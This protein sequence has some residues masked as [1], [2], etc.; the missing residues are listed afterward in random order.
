MKV[1]VKVHRV[2]SS[3][4][5]LVASS[6]PFPLHRAVIGDSKRVVTPFMQDR[7]YLPRNFATLGPSRLR[8]P[9]TEPY[10]TL[11]FLGISTGQASD[12][13]LHEHL[14]KS[15]VF[16]K[17]S[18]SSFFLFFKFRF[19]FQSYETILPSSFNYLVSTACTYSAINYEFSAVRS[20]ILILFIKVISVEL[21]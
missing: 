21:N 15:C 12:F 3:S 13:I 9:F 2:F 5:G 1:R 14:A 7:N 20:H 18:L 16:K 17:Q 10:R 11:F 6:R 4:Y 8:P 19:L